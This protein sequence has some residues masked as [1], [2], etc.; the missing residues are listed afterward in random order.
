[1]VSGSVCAGSPPA[2]NVLGPVKNRARE[3]ATKGCIRSRIFRLDSVLI[4]R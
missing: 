1:M 2:L 3:P 4:S